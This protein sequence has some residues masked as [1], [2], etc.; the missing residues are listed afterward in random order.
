LFYYKTREDIDGYREKSAEL[1]FQ[2]L[3]AQMEFFHRAMPDRAKKMSWS[4]QGGI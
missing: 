4:D 1:K 3:E 2:W